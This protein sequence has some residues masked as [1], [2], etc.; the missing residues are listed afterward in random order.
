[1]KIHYSFFQLF[2]NY[3]CFSILVIIL[4]FGI[5]PTSL[6][7]GLPSLKIKR[8]G[9]PLTE[10]SLAV[11]KFSSVL[12]LTILNLPSKSRAISSSTG[13]NYLQ[14]PHQGA[15]KSTI[16]SSDELTTSASKFPSLISNAFD[17]KVSSLVTFHNV[18]LNC[19]KKSIN[20]PDKDI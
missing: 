9:K 2:I 20:R 16:V 5:K 10:Y 17:M 8:V 6:S 7:T 4:V 14:G 13:P 19:S 11:F 15:Q 18:Y 12:S 1:M 3:K